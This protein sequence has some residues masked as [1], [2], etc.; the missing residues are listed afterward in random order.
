MFNCKFR[1]IIKSPIFFAIVILMTQLSCSEQ[2]LFVKKELNQSVSLLTIEGFSS[3]A[4]NA[5][6]TTGS[7]EL[8]VVDENSNTKSVK[9][10]KGVSQV[11]FLTDKIGWLIDFDSQIWKTVDAGLTWVKLGQISDEKVSNKLWRQIHFVNE[12]SGFAI[13]PFSVRSTTDGGKTWNKIYPN[14][15]TLNLKLDSEP[16]RLF[17][18][19]SQNILVSMT[20]GKIIKTFDGGK[21][22]GSVSLKKR[23]DV[24]SI[25]FIDKTAGCV[26][27]GSSGGIY[28]TSNG[29]ET[30]EQKLPSTLTESLGINSVWLTGNKVIWG[31][32]KN[33][34]KP[35][36]NSS[37]ESNAILLKSTDNG[38]TWIVLNTELNEKEFIRIN[39]VDD[40]NGWLVS[41]KAVFKTIN[42]GNDWQKVFE[43]YS[44]DK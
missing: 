2:K 15:S 6:L 9:F 25:W 19:D 21:H 40:Q 33:F 24:T 5:W 31:A 29:G 7:G 1:R 11:Y 39:F 34:I 37:E 8:I 44:K 16:L 42:G 14:E 43:V 23:I 41:E 18:L 3:N 12:S 30:W 13:S 4:K 36:E 27:T 35:L 32:G 28:C 20:N 22:W 26:G 17:P 10:E 38:Q